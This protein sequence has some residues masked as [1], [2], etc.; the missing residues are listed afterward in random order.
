[1]QADRIDRKLGL[2]MYV[3]NLTLSDLN[4]MQQMHGLPTTSLFQRYDNFLVVTIYKQLLL[5]NLFRN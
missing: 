3:H 5:I 2:C 4:C 1:M